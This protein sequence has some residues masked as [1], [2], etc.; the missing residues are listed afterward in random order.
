MVVVAGTAANGFNPP[1]CGGMLE[2]TPEPK[3]F[4]LELSADLQTCLWATSFAA[5][6]PASLHGPRLAAVPGV[7]EHGLFGPE[8]VS[9]VLVGRGDGVEKL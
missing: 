8:L 6:T 1:Q 3:I 2:S 7:V 4:L 5:T 9:E